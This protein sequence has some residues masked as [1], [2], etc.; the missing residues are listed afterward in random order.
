MDKAPVRGENAEHLEMAACFI[1]KRPL[2]IISKPLP[3]NPRIQ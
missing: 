3:G 2:N 1:F